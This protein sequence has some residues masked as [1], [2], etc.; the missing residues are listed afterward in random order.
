MPAPCVYDTVW[1]FSASEHFQGDLLSLYNG[2]LQ[3]KAMASFSSGITRGG[4]G[5]T[6]IGS[7]RA[8]THSISNFGE[9]GRNWTSYSVLLRE[10]FWQDENSLPVSYRIFQSILRNVS[11]L[12]IRGDS[13]FAPI[14]AM[15][16]ETVY[17]ND[18]RL[19]S[20]PEQR[21]FHET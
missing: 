7:Q 8:V 14:R 6:L 11:A 21:G 19:E 13:P 17:V 20:R 1:Y 3:F 5:I 9:I 12:L 18:I 2:R 10:E 15:E 4:R 16:G